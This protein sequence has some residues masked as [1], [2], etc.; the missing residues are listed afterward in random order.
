MIIGIMGLEL[1]L[2]IGGGL[3]L[4]LKDSKNTASDAVGTADV[5]RII[6]LGESTTEAG[7]RF[8]WPAQLETILNKR[9]RK[10]EFKVINEGVGGTNTSFIL[11]RLEK[12][13]DKHRPHMIISMMGGNDTGA[14]MIYDDKDHKILSFLK[15]LRVYKLFRLM[16]N[17]ISPRM[18]KEPGADADDTASEHIAAKMGST[19]SNLLEKAE[20]HHSNGFIQEAEQMYRKA[21]EIDPVHPRAYELLG[22]SYIG[23]RR[24]QEAEEVYI[25]L[26]K[27]DPDNREAYSR[28]GLAYAKQKRYEEAKDMYLKIVELNSADDIVYAE[29]GMIFRELGVAEEEIETF[30]KE[31]GLPVKPPPRPDFEITKYHYQKMYEILNERDIKLIAMQYPTLS[32]DKLKRKFNGSEEIIFLSN[33]ENFSDALRNDK[34]E[35]YFID[36]CYGSFG[37]ATPE[38]NKLIAENAAD[39]ILQLRCRV[40]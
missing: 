17:S 1:L 28:L 21:I 2:R 22:L 19:Y 12:N 5:Y 38:G 30:Y 35:K 3:H 25:K 11:S 34:Y 20:K 15:N 36:R 24:L 40:R 14:F 7:G 37:H 9:S 39:V 26:L 32:V 27:Y 8:A 23:S 33:K 29:L 13:L 6:C 10:I 31:R 4:Y 16:R 18:K